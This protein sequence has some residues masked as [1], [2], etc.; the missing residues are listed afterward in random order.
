MNLLMCEH[1]KRSCYRKTIRVTKSS[2]GLACGRGC[3][4]VRLLGI[5]RRRPTI[6]LP[7]GNVP[8][9]RTL[10]VGLI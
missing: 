2:L 7:P 3:A 10:L 9:Y 6:V 5:G 4:M 8:Y 1:T